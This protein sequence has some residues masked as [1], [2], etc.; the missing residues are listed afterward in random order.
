MIRW[1]EDLGGPAAVTAVDL[2][3][4]TTAPQWNEWASYITAGGAYLGTFMGW[5]GDFVR[6]A[7]HAAFPWAAKKV[8]ERVKGGVSSPA[9]K[10]VHRK[11][12]R[13]P[14]AQIEPQFQGVKLI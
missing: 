13:Y 10:L 9:T 2:I 5:G 11:V 1:M 3:T 4:E 6:A 8:Y 7:A 14:S 12:A